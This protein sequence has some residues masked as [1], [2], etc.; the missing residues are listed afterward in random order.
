MK[1]TRLVPRPEAAQPPRWQHA[2]NHSLAVVVDGDD[3]TDGSLDGFPVV[4][5]A[6]FQ[7]LQLFAFLLQGVGLRP[8][9][10]NARRRRSREG[11]ATGQHA[12]CCRRVRESTCAE[13]C[14]HFGP[15]G[16]IPTERVEPESCIWHELQSRAIHRFRRDGWTWQQRRDVQ[17][18]RM[19]S[20][21]ALS[22]K[23]GRRCQG[24]ENSGLGVVRSEKR[25]CKALLGLLS[26][27]MHLQP[28][29][30][31]PVQESQI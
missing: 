13:S 1:I 10:C 29:K 15:W 27:Y 26:I 6:I 30:F 18:A 28:K 21:Q 22:W 3:G 11:F 19:R 17:T 31:F 24:L 2:T 4:L 20:E 5:Q 14:A 8:T 9:L 25:R 16:R 23:S 12:R 7:R